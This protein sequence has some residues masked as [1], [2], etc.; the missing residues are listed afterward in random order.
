MDPNKLTQKTGEALHE[1]RRARLRYGHTEIDVEHLLVALLEQPDASC[2]ASSRG[3]TPTWTRSWPS[4]GRASRAAARDRVGR[5]GRGADLTRARDAPRRRRA[6]RRRLKDEYVSVEHVLLAIIDTGS[7]TAA[8]RILKDHG[9][10]AD[11][12]LQVLTEVRGS[13][14][15]TS[16]NPKSLTRRR[17]VRPRLVAEARSGKLDR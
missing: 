4:W 7:S 10:T 3:S 12:F 14:R 6:A 16:A 5:H 9:V 13:Q 11:R 15:V 8:G 1:R 17:E 2:R